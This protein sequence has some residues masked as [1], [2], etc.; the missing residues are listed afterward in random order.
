[1]ARDTERH[2]TLESHA[3]ARYG[4]LI[5]HIPDSNRAS[6][7]FKALTAELIL[8][9][10]SNGMPKILQGHDFTLIFLAHS[11]FRRGDLTINIVWIIIPHE[12]IQMIPFWYHFGRK[13]AAVLLL[14]RISA[15][16]L[17]KRDHILV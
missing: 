15:K 1:M 10:D 5:T 14:N 12:K 6:H 13:K 4:A 3:C 11:S 2:K 9:E 7:N 8:E 17:P 16:M